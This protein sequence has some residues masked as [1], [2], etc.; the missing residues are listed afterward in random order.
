M[1]FG[2]YYIG[3]DFGGMQK[4]QQQLNAG[5]SQVAMNQ[6]MAT[7]TNDITITA[8][9]HLP[10]DVA[11]MFNGSM[12]GTSTTNVLTSH[13]NLASLATKDQI[14]RLEKQINE[15]EQKVIKL[16]N[17]LRHYEDHSMD[18]LKKSILDF[19]LVG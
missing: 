4:A 10:E 15:L 16:S 19:R 2:D 12:N 6:Q 9:P 8:D 18:S 17:R 13:K 7:S 3:T 14:E 5:M 11:Y 1:S